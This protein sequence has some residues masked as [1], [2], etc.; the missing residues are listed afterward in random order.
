MAVEQIATSGRS[1]DVLVG[2]A[3]TGKSTTMAGLRA[4]WEA[5]HGAGS[6]LGLAPS[7]AAAEVLAGELGIDTENTAKWLYEHRQEAERLSRAGGSSPRSSGRPARRSGAVRRCD[8]ASPRP[9]TRWPAGGSGEANSSSSRKPPWRARSLS[10]NWSRAA[11]DAGA[12]VLLVGD[13][14]QL[15]AV[16]AGGMFAAL[17]RDRDGLAPEL[18]DVRRFHNAWE[19]RASVQLRAGSEDAIDAYE[20][21]DR[22]VSGDRDEMLDAVFAAWKRRRR[23]GTHEPD[24]RG[25]SGHRQRAQRP[26]PGRPD[27]RRAGD[28]RGRQRR[29]WRNGGGG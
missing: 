14:A 9:R 27:L 4:V 8:D 19:Q 7:A 20:A 28:R 29:R 24:D 26:G 22:I 21:H 1:L 6:V 5:E 10:T 11:S 13:Q 25:R 23:I 12:K 3:G 18:S 15:S 16:E 2:P 17:V